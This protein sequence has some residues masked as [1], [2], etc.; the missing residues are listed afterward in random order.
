MTQDRPAPAFPGLL[1]QIA[2]LGEREAVTVTAG[3]ADLGPGLWLSCDPSGQAVMGCHPAGAGFRLTVGD[4]DSGAWACLG[5]RLPP[6]TLGRGRYLGVLS[7]TE[8]GALVSFAPSLRYH[9]EDGMR[10]VAPPEPVVQPSGRRTQ[11]AHI[12]IDPALPARASRCE[13]NLFFH[14]G[15]VDMRFF[16]LE[17]LLIS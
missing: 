4:G 2:A 5:M 12:P 11:L 10:D 9:L 7:E 8:S 6:E 3:H 17:P 14:T 15:Q 16:R 13:L 1:A